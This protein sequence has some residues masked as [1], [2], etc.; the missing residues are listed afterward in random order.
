MSRFW[1]HSKDRNSVWR[2]HFTTIILLFLISLC[3]YADQNLLS[4]NLTAVAHSFGFGP[5]E[6]DWKLGGQIGFGFFVMGGAASVVVGALADKSDRRYLLTIVVLCGE[7]PSLLLIVVTQYW[8]LFICR[9]MT[10]IAVGGAL[11][12]SLSILGDVFPST[13]RALVSSLWGVA[14][15]IG[16]LV[17]QGLAGYL[18]EL[19]G[20]RF[21]FLVVSVPTMIC[22]CLFSTIAVDP[23]RGG[24][25]EAFQG[26]DET[27]QLLNTPRSSTANTPY[28]GLKRHG[29]EEPQQP[30]SPAGGGVV[31]KETLTFAKAKSI[32]YIPTNLLGFLQGMPGCV[33][34]GV[35]L[36]YFTDYLAQ[37]KGLGIVV[38]TNIMMWVN[39]GV[40][41]GGVV[42]GYVGQ[43]LYNRKRSLQALL[44]GSTTMFGAVPALYLTIVDYG[45]A[46]TFVIYIIAFCFGGIIAVTGSNVRAVILNVNMPET[47][48]TVFGVF[49]LTDDIGKGLGPVLI[50]LLISTVGR[51]KAICVGFCCWVLCALL[52]GMMG[53]TM[54]KDEDKVQTQLKKSYQPI[55]EDDPTTV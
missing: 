20:W 39:T 2:H 23:P 36:Q 33:P 9:T 24:C 44:M 51:F 43:K 10:G 18:G 35:L 26:V 53:L 47:R 42:G 54:E 34:W 12:L 29:K 22:A 48:G 52:L 40:I 16:G 28:N 32:F 4:P 55:S 1:P 13:Q 14:L 5:A 6:R 31:Y 50:A 21:P 15:G 38:A 41:I 7:I 19:M 11:P 49:A 3:L 25:E 8:Q 45:T 46:N 37:D 17:G 27:Q 30:E